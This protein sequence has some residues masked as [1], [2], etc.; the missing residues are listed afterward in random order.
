MLRLTSCIFLICSSLG[1]IFPVTSTETCLQQ[2]HT[3]QFWGENYTFCHF[4]LTLKTLRKWIEIE[5]NMAA[6]SHV[7]PVTSVVVL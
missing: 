1:P 2:G 4:V 7:G 3:L 6:M 5:N